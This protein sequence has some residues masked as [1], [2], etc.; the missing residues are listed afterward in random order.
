MSTPTPGPD[1]FEI[2]GRAEG[3]RASPP[4]RPRHARPGHRPREPLAPAL[5]PARVHP[6]RLVERRLEAAP[7][8]PV[9]L[10]TP[11]MEGALMRKLYDLPPPGERELYVSDL[12]AARRAAPRRSSC[13][14]TRPRASGTRTVDARAAPRFRDP[15]HD[16]AAPGPSLGLGEA[17]PG[18]A[19]RFS[20]AAMAT[21]FEIH[22]VHARRPVLPRRPRRPPSPSSI[23]SS[24]C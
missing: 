21:V 5:V 13:A 3:P 8:A 18:G 10:A 1:V 19:R 7:S 20:H 11:D 22:C 23:S 14:A 4:G 24:N 2:A 9:I 17:R 12:R 16:V 15:G 6:G